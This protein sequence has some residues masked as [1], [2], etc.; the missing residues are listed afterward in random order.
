MQLPVPSLLIELC[1]MPKPYAFKIACESLIVASIA[2]AGCATSPKIETIQPVEAPAFS[3]TGERAQATP[4]W[5]AFSSPPLES[6]IEEALA[7]N[8][9]LA[10]AWE[11]L[12]SARELARR[13]QADLYP[14]LDATAGAGYS[15]G[16]AGSGDPRFSLGLEA[17]WEI[18]L[19]GRIDAE[20]AAETIRLG[21][22]LSDYHAAAVSLTAEV[23][24]NWFRIVETRGQSR[25]LQS[26]LETNEAV[27]N[28]LKTRFAAGQI[29]N[30]DVLRQERLTETTREQFAIIEGRLRILNHQLA[31]I[32]GRAPQ[33]FTA[34]DGSE[35]PEMDPLPST[36]LPADLVERR[37]DVRSARLA[38]AAALKDTEAAFSARFPRISL[39]A[40]LA[41]S[42]ERP[43][44]LFANW[45]ASIAGQLT[46]P[47]FDAGQ[48]KAE[49]R[50]REAI[51][52][53]QLAA[54]GSSVINAF[55]EVENSLSRESTAARRVTSLRTQLEIA[56]QTW[57]QLRVQYLNG[58]TDYLNVLD[59]LATT[60]RLERDLL[61]ARFDQVASRI[62]L[63]RALAGPLETD[64]EVDTLTASSANAN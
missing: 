18:D 28:L 56:R 1:P 30:A 37:P 57:R 39:G 6:L 38:V 53:Q 33:G 17:A 52:R 64:R 32:L 29:R 58:V 61:Q 21:A 51:V 45:L 14:T 55:A 41:T 15:G 31:L 35:L 24:D 26:Q 46:A 44:D 47:V 20:V 63:H 16:S 34:P 50:N 13:S 23:A 11:R 42:A 12:E 4:W 2:L 8:Y 22:R 27:L 9:D 49:V 3:D 54:Y 5:N 7:N 25:L 59:A 62:E 36:G 19:W 60:Q 43:A 48:R 40:T 10:I